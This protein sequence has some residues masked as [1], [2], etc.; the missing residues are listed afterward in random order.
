MVDVL[1]DSGV[2]NIL[3]VF[4]DVVKLFFGLWKLMFCVIKGVSDSEIVFWEYVIVIVEFEYVFFE[5]DLVVVF[6]LCMNILII[7]GID[8]FN[9]D[10]I[11]Y[12]RIKD[13]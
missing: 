2:I 12:I 4:L 3:L 6:V 13:R 8:V 5:V 11:V 10:G 1:I 9:R 7:I